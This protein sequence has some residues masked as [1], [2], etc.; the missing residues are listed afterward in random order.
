M[1]PNKHLRFRTSLYIFSLSPSSLLRPYL[2]D[3]GARAL[4]P[5]AS[6]FSFGLWA[7]PS[8]ALPSTKSWIRPRRYYPNLSFFPS[9]TISLS[10]SLPDHL[11]YLL[12]MLLWRGRKRHIWKCRDLCSNQITP[13]F[14]S[15]KEEWAVAFWGR[16][17][18]SRKEIGKIF[19]P[20]SQ[21]QTKES[22]D[23]KETAIKKG[24]RKTTKW[25]PI[26]L[27]TRLYTQK[28]RFKTPM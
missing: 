22:L 21:N 9:I 19:T 18:T 4:H 10:P 28:F 17:H 15:S 2:G 26:V 25:D 23:I 13:Q 27:H 3:R 1:L 16:H 14:S 6:F 20:K 8:W 11:H 12:P 7:L 24:V 5:H